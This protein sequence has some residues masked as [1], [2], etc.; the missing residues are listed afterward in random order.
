MDGIDMLHHV[1]IGQNER[2][3]RGTEAAGEV[4]NECV[5]KVRC[6]RTVGAK[7]VLVTRGREKYRLI[8]TSLHTYLA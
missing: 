6:S 3:N 2:T 8:A 5:V 4:G 1:A 7:A